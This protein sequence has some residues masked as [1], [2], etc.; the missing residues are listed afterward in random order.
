MRGLVLSGGGS[1]GAFQI[2][3]LKRW[4]VDQG[5]DYDVIAGSSVGAINAA[6]LCHAPKGVPRDAWVGAW[7]F[8][9]RV[10]NRAIRREWPVLGKVAALWR[11]S[12]YDSSPLQQWVRREL[13]LPA[14]RRSGRR[15]LVTAVS[16]QTGEACIVDQDDPAFADWI[17]ASSSFPAMLNPITIHGEHWTDGSVRSVTPLSAAIKA[18]CTEVD[19]ILCADPTRPTAFDFGGKAAVPWLAFRAVE[20]LANEVARGDLE[21]A[22]LK[23]RIEGYKQIKLRICK[24]DVDLDAK[25]GPALDFDIDLRGLIQL[26]YET[27]CR[28]DQ[29]EQ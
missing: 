24:P 13:N 10:D 11:T 12:V 28:L 15:V 17:L 8:W 18:G 9:A 5:R 19:V 21:I 22:E 1:K 25:F 27:A 7:D 26:G 16:W 14:I 3:V 29:A 6:L 2:G 4:M 20:I 23:N